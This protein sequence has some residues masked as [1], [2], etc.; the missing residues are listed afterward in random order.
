M[1]E[2]NFEEQ[3]NGLGNRVNNMAISEANCQGKT[4]ERLNTME[5]R[6]GEQRDDIKE[7][8]GKIETVNTALSLLSG[9]ISGGFVILSIV[10]TII[11]PFITI[12]ANRLIFGR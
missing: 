11:I 1:N 12:F 6:Q 7:I 4:N 2:N 10:L 9:K 5:K 8:F 3:M